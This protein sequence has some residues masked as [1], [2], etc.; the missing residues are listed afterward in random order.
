MTITPVFVTTE[1]GNKRTG[2]MC[3]E[4]S[5]LHFVAVFGK[6]REEAIKKAIEEIT[7]VF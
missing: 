2:Y 7:R 5:P 4:S 3:S 1:E 6:T